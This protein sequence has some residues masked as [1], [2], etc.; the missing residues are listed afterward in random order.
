MYIV[1]Q[2]MNLSNRIY[3]QN[4]SPLSNQWGR[5]CLAVKTVPTAAEEHLQGVTQADGQAGETTET[6]ASAIACLLAISVTVL[7]DS[8]QD[9]QIFRIIRFHGNSSADMLQSCYLIAYAIIGQGAEIIPACAA[10]L[11]IIQHIQRLLVAAVADIL[12]GRILIRIPRLPLL[13]LL[14][15]ATERIEGIVI[16][17]ILAV[18]AI[19]TSSA[20]FIGVLNLVIGRVDL[21]H[22]PGSFRVTGV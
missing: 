4:E 15:V 6:E 8:L 3:K 22:L 5:Y 10:H 1:L 20:G 18:L 9:S 21:L 19:L 16:A 13:G 7:F 14:I 17:A 12:I 11:R 2:A